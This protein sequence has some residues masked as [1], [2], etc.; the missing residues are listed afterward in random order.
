M[1]L[2]NIIYLH[3]QNIGYQKIATGLKS[4]NNILPKLCKMEKVRGIQEQPVW[5][6]K[7]TPRFIQFIRR[8]VDEDPRK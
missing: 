8:L 4:G 7:L 5:P 3:K 1:I 2:E 6:S